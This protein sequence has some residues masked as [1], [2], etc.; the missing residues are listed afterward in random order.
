[1][2]DASKEVLRMPGY[3]IPECFKINQNTSLECILC[4]NEEINTYNL[5][6]VT[7]DEVVPTSDIAI[8][9]ESLK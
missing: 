1:M 8:D 5:I 3:L 6:S 7:L 9:Y 2:A 4:C